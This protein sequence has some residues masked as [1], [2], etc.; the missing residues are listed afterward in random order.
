MVYFDLLVQR[1]G[2]RADGRPIDVIEWLHFTTFD[3]AGDLEFGESFGCLRDGRLHPWIEVMLSHFKRLV[4]L[5][6]VLIIFPALRVAIPWLVP[7]KV[8]EQRMQR[9]DFASMK[10]GK[11]LDAGEND[12]RADFMTYVCRHND[13]KGMSRAE[14]DATFEIL[15]SASS[16]TTATALTGWVSLLNTPYLWILRKKWCPSNLRSPIC[17][18]L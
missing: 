4:I 6:S 11:R 17:A 3:I 9:F 18:L 7:K 15:V 2:E 1:L 16:E 10:V 13:E 5:G 8:Q 12:K 14:L